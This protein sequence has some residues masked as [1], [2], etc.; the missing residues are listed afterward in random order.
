L[1]LSRKFILASHGY[2]IFPPNYS[3]WLDIRSNR[4]FTEFIRSHVEAR[5]SHVQDS[6]ET[7]PDYQ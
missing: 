7:V 4:K 5:A 1:N 2:F 6:S 3:V